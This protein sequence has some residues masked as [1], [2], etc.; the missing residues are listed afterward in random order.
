MTELTTSDFGY[1][2]FSVKGKIRLTYIKGHYEVIDTDNGSVMLSDGDCSLIV[3]RKRITC[4]E[5]KELVYL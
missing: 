2:E 5:K 3:E 1:F 4:F